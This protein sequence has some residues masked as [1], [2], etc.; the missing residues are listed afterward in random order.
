VG[1]AGPASWEDGVGV[2]KL[3]CQV[4]GLLRSWPLA[5]LSEPS[6]LERVLL[7]LNWP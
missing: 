2:L 7:S 5:F 1:N 6:F 4:K 3:L